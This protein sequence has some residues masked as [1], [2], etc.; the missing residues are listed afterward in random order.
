LLNKLQGCINWERKK[1]TPQGGGGQI[2]ADVIRRENI[3]ICKRKKGKCERKGERQKT[4]GEV[5]RVK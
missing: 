3:K 5:E 1:L 2:S 4:K